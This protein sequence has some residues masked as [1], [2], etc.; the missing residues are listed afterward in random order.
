MRIIAG[1]FRSRVL[2][3]PAGMETRP[4]SDRLRETLFNVLQARFS[5]GMQGLRFLDLFAG[6][7]A[8]GLEA[9]SR[10]AREAVLVE[11]A[12]PALAAIRKNA[13]VLG[14][15]A[16]LKIDGMAV[17]RWLDAAARTGRDGEFSVIFLDPPYE[18][19]TEYAGT[20]ERLGGV[21][22]GLLASGGVVVAEHRK[23][24][25]GGAR[26]GGA[27]ANAASAAIPGERY[28]A[29]QRTRVLT[30]GDAGLSFYEKE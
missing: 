8:N 12:A 29:L 9:L 10:G 20:L 14:V 23:E 11:K 3:A 18:D 30:Q 13:T 19:A 21:A 26:R 1:E 27:A 4:T 6:S 7:G 15:V 16:R 25:A 24:H 22:S 28:G 2:S 5:E 17:S